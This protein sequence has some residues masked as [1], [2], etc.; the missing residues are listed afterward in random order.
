[1]NRNWDRYQRAVRGC[2][3]PWAGDAIWAWRNRLF[4]AL[5]AA[6]EEIRPC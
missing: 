1:M 2:S 4:V 6:M 3:M 5:N